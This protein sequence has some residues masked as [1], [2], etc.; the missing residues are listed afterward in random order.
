MASAEKGLALKA[1][2]AIHACRH[3][4]T[5]RL[6]TLRNQVFQQ[7]PIANRLNG[8]VQTIRYTARKAVRHESGR[9]LAPPSFD[10][11]A[12]PHR[13]LALVADPARR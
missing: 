9:A 13:R 3:D 12:A 5:H 8:N 2:G 7:A 10:Q 4:V 11:H 1:H 6:W